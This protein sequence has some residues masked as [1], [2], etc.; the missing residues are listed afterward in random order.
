MI[1]PHMAYNVP[2]MF[3]VLCYGCGMAAY[4]SALVWLA[5]VMTGR[6]NNS[7]LKVMTLVWPARV[8]A[9]FAFLSLVAMFMNSLSGTGNFNLMM[10]ELSILMLLGAWALLSVPEKPRQWDYILGKQLPIQIA[11]AFGVFFIALAGW[12]IAFTLGWILM[13]LGTLLAAPDW[14]PIFVTAVLFVTPLFK[15]FRI[16]EEK[17]IMPELTLSYVLLPLIFA[18]FLIIL[19]EFFE[20][21]GNSPKIEEFVKARPYLGRV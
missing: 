18:C 13:Q 10:P 16:V 3:R 20:H 6:K 9:V 17:Q 8:L 15:M 12:A 2:M 4:A 7:T 5:R 14:V 1:D 21:L 11:K 19:P